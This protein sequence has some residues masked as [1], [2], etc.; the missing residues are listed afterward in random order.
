MQ[1]KRAH[2]CQGIY[3]WDNRKSAEAYKRRLERQDVAGLRI[4][5]FR[6]KK[7]VLHSFRQIDLD[8]LGDPGADEWFQRYS[9]LSDENAPPHYYSCVRRGTDF[10]V[11]HFF[12]ST[13]FRHLQFR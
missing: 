11:E 12:S 5:A 3:S 13:V 2:L 6:I 1:S 9:K 4:V 7:R 8:A 10:G